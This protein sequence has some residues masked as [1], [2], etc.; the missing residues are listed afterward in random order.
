MFGYFSNAMS[1][2]QRPQIGI[3]ITA[4]NL[5]TLVPP[6]TIWYDFSSN[7]SGYVSPAN[8]ASGS[9]ITA[10]SD[11]TGKSHPT[12]TKGGT[13]NWLANASGT[14]GAANTGTAGG[15]LNTP[16]TSYLR[17]LA[18]MTVIVAAKP[19]TTM[20]TGYLCNTD[21][22]DLAIYYSSSKWNVKCSGGTGVPSG[23]LP[24]VL[25]T[26][27]LFSFVYNGAGAGNANRLRFRYNK[28]D[29]ALNISG[30][31]SATANSSNDNYVWFSQ[32]SSTQNPFKG[33]IGEVLLFNTALNPGQVSAIEQYLGSKWGI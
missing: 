22:G 27:Q 19:T 23:S 6:T 25:N 18:G 28:A 7:A 12:T 10:A 2:G 33:Q 11:R 5:V 17:S 21:Q 15:Y 9:P 20:T 8:V 13:V 4:S 30:T 29:V 3:Q 31:V 14:L 26:W 24:L 1:F 16:S 32:D